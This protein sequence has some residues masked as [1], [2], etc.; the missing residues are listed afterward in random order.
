MVRPD[1]PRSIIEF[2]RR[3]PDDQACREYLLASRWPEGFRCP[4][5][6]GPAATPLPRR[7]LLPCSGCRHQVS[8][9]AGTV[10][11]KTHT[12]LHLWFWA[13]YLMSTATPGISALQL[14]RQLGV[15]RYETAWM[16]LHK[17]RR[18]MVNPERKPLTQSVEVDEC[19]VGGHEAGLRGGRARGDKALVIV[20]AEVLGAG[21]GRIRMAI[22]DDASADQLTGFVRANIA[23][24]APPCTPTPATATCRCAG[25][26]TT[27]SHA[28]S[29]PPGPAGRTPTTSCP[30][31]TA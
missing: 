25:T 23:P 11:H 6:S 20:G 4:R 22:L 16:I 24:G 2:Q 14:Q 21:T 27:T 8:A 5:C 31:C 12:P 7:L 9:T 17:L 29:A 30:A 15:K 3:F 13:A 28:A 18:A 19:F 26:A 1:F 10:L